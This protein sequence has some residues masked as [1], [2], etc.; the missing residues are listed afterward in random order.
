MLFFQGLC[1]YSRNRSVNQRTKK[2]CPCSKFDFERKK[3]EINSNEIGAKK[4]K[5]DIYHHFVLE[6]ILVKEDFK[7]NKGQLF[8]YC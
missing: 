5:I 1:Y 6:R 7:A 4:C 8:V 3:S 2:L